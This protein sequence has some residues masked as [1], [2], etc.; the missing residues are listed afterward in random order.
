MRT[1]KNIT[2]IGRCP[3]DPA[4][5]TGVGGLEEGG[6]GG[7][8]EGGGLE[9]GGRRETGEVWGGRRGVKECER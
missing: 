8:G 5:D 4:L 3:I 7:G 2:Q 6:G 1:V 9:K